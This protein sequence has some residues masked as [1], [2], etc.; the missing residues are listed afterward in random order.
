MV[1]TGDTATIAVRDTG[2]GIPK[3]EQDQ[4]FTR[5]FRTTNAQVS[6]IKGTGLG[7][8]ITRGIIEAHGGTINFESVEGT[9]TTFHFTLPLAHGLQLE[10]V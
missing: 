7:L 2:I 5:F 8:A 9:G 10:V 6:G 1:H 4:M 3:D